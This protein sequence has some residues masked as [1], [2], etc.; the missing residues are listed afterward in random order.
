MSAAINFSVCVPEILPYRLTK[1][2]DKLIDPG[3]LDLE[4]INLK[5]LF[6]FGRS[7]LTYLFL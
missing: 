4:K 1:E 2:N 3:A 7:L 5:N 6:R